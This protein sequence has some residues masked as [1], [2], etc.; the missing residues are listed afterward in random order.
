MK[1]C[2]ACNTE[3]PESE[4]YRDSS[5]HD[6]L[7][8]RCKPCHKAHVA[9][10]AMQPPRNPAPEGM[11][12]CQRCKETKPLDQFFGHKG[13]WDGKQTMCKP[14]QTKRHQQWVEENREQ[15]NRYARERY[16][17]EPDR[18]AD[19]DRKKKYG[20]PAGRYIEMLAEQGGVCAICKS[21]DPGA[22]AF[23]VDHCHDTGAVRGLL[24]GKCNNGIG[25]LQHSETILLSAIDYL[26]N[27]K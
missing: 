2:K 11:K 9:A 6:G 15:V 10:I 7:N 17:K 16:K 20:L 21:P 14:C 4:F 12:R 3:K 8:W 13:S 19:Y 18:Y 25:Q 1:L 24:C 26:R 22:R 27:H 5:R 23:H